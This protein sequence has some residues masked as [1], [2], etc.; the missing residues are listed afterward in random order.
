MGEFEKH[1]TVD[2]LRRAWAALREVN[3][4]SYKLMALDGAKRVADLGCGPGLDAVHIAQ[5]M[6]VG[7]KVVG[8]DLSADMLEAAAALVKERGL[9]DRVELVRDSVLKLPFADGH[10]DAVRA[11]RLF[12]VLPQD[13]CPPQ[14]VFAE[15]LRV[16]RPGGRLVLV[17]MDWG[18]ASVDFPDIDLERRMV[19]FFARK[20]RPNGYVGRQ[21][22]GWMLGAGMKDVAMQEFPRVMHSLDD[23]PL[24]Q[25]LADEALRGKAVSEADACR[26]MD[27]LKAKEADGKLLVS[28]NMVVAAGRKS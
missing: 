8:L 26:W 12:Q 14:V 23:C 7:G 10:F 4:L 9:A 17:D 21:F 18:T 11:M 3:E 28:A 6:P 13:T 16:L 2:Y 5:R 27:V 25:W 22:Y 24:G 15:M 20:V 1:V 19:E